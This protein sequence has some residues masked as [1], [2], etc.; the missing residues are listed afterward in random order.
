MAYSTIKILSIIILF[1]SL[2]SQ[3]WACSFRDI[4]ISQKQ[5][6]VQVQGKPEWTV[7]VT[8]NCACVQLNV[9]LKCSGFQSVEKIDSSIL[10]VSS[11]GCL[12]N[13]GLP[14]YRDAVQFNYASDQQFAFTPI[15]SQIACS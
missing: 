14:I 15:S 6:G 5:T 1:L 13:N 10:S 7:T 8:N 3:G 2:S 9:I 12:L 11:G 4:S